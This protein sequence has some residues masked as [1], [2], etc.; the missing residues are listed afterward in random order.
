ML[1]DIKFRVCIDKKVTK[2]YREPPLGWSILESG[3]IF[4]DGGSL[5]CRS[6]LHLKQIGEKE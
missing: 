5:V 6:D 4:G 3:V 2:M 1:Y